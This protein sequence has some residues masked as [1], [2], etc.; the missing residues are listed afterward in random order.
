MWT[1]HVKRFLIGLFL[2]SLLLS[3]TVPALATPVLYNG[4][5]A[6]LE[7]IQW[8]TASPVSAQSGSNK[9][10]AGTYRGITSML[11]GNWQRFIRSNNALL[12]DLYLP[13]AALSSMPTDSPIPVLAS[14]WADVPG[15]H[16]IVFEL[17]PKATWSDGIPITTKDIIQTLFHLSDP[18]HHYYFQQRQIDQYITGIT[19][20]DSGHFALH[21][22]EHLNRAPDFLFQLRP[23]AAHTMRKQDEAP[24]VSGAYIPVELTINQLTL[25]RLSSWWGDAL[26]AFQKRFLLRR[27]VLNK[28]ADD[29][30]ERFEQGQIDCIDTSAVVPEPGEWM[31]R[32]NTKEQIT[33]VISEQRPQQSTFLIMPSRLH[34]DDQK[35]IQDYTEDLLR[36]T[37]SE[38]PPGLNVFYTSGPTA[39][40]LMNSAARQVAHD[41][42]YSRLRTGF[43][44]GLIATLPT[45]YADE[46]VT[47]VSL[48]NEALKIVPLYDIPYHLHACWAWVALPEPDAHQD[49]SLSPLNPI[50]GGYLGIDRRKRTRVLNHPDRAQG[51]QPV[52]LYYTDKK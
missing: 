43:F 6:D 48:S 52:I 37:P 7:G 45:Q 8:S 44:E 25:E 24:A 20:Y 9:R 17:Q 16:K 5:A 28:S 34:S 26:P 36:G 21:Y 27:I 3:N 39:E 47:K 33:L 2:G 13:L 14:R 12:Q 38:L 1:S 50:D 31:R 23:F 10:I 29:S 18:T 46:I 49:V 22:P 15:E 35:A 42:L 30:I 11:P 40:W 4:T 19:R 41:E 51:D 32:L